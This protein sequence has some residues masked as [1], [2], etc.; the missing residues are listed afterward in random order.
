MKRQTTVATVNRNPGSPDA[1]LIGCTCPE[2]SN[3]WGRHPGRGYDDG[4]AVWEIR[5]SCPLHWTDDMA[6]T[7]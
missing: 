2:I 3:C 1:R 5:W 7:A 4:V 6:V